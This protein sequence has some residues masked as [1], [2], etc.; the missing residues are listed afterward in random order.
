MAKVQIKRVGV[1][2]C[3]KIYAITLAAFG[4]IIGVIYGLLFMIV[5]GAMMAGGGRDSGAAGASS[6]VIGLIMMV[7][8]PVLYGIIGFIAGII[9]GVVY[10]VASGVVGGLELELENVDGGAGYAPPAPNWGD[11]PPYTP[12]QQQQYPY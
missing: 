11:Q 10:N 3:A 5:G 7:A 8:I 9:G 1:F 4:I 12:G 6:L 2:S